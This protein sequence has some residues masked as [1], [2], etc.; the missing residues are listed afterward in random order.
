[1][2]PEYG[3]TI[4]IFPVDQETLRYL[5]FTGRPAE[6]VQLV[7]AYMKEQG[8]FHTPEAAEPV[9]SDTLELNLATVEPSMAGPR[10]PQDRVGLR[11]VPRKFAEALPTL[12]KPA[13]VPAVDAVPVGRGEGEGGQGG[14]RPPPPRPTSPS[15]R[16]D[17]VEHGLRHGPGVV[18]AVTRCTKTSH[19]SGMVGAGPL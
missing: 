3:A 5:E 11:E 4:G 8:L 19:P 13:P 7:E 14:L 18:A 16:I 6:H 10:R 17:D 12:M 9:Y 2:A 1:M 15:P